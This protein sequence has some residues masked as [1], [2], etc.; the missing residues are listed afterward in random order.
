MED[1]IG[2]TIEKWA[3]MLAHGK[4]DEDITQA[5]KEY[6]AF[7]KKLATDAGLV[8][9]SGFW[10]E[11]FVKSFRNHNVLLKHRQEILVVLF[12]DF[13]VQEVE[14]ELQTYFEKL[15]L[16]EQLELLRAL[17]Q[18]APERFVNVIA[19]FEE[20][21]ANTSNAFKTFNQKR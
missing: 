6:G 13:P 20:T 16:P 2:L 8:G 17:Q 11:G 15:I 14:D 21:L 1:N 12:N 19:S 4:T 9:L 7:R 5:L 10:S 18:Y 3:G